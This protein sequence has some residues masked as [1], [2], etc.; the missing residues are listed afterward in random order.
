MSKGYFTKNKAYLIMPTADLTNTIL[1]L[2]RKACNIVG[3]LD[4]N[5]LRKNTA[6]D[7]VVVELLVDDL[8]LLNDVACNVA[9]IRVEL[10]KAEWN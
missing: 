3:T 4:S 9:D 10:A 5:S 1:N 2:S 7:K 8:P 6:G